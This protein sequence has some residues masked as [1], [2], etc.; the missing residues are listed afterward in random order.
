MEVPGGG[1]LVERDEVLCALD[2]LI[3]AAARGAGRVLVVE[4]PPGVGK[5]T[6]LRA[7]AE[8]ASAAGMR[9]LSAS[10][11]E[12]E[13]ELAY[14]VVR[15]LFVGVG[16]GADPDVDLWDGAAGLARRVVDPAAAAGDLRAEPSAVMHGLV[17][18]CASLARRAGLALLVDDVHWADDSSLRWL[19]YLARRAADLP[20]LVVLARRPLAATGGGD[21]LAGVIADPATATWPLESL[22][23]DGSAALVR[24][25]VGV[26][27]PAEI[28]RACHAATGGN[29]FYLSEMVAAGGDAL[30]SA[31]ASPVASLAPERVR[32]SVLARLDGLGPPAVEMARAIAVLGA[33]VEV[34]H[35]AALA[36]LDP[37]IADSVADALATAGILSVNR[38]LDFAHPIIRTAVYGVLPEGARSALH[39]RAAHVLYDDCSDPAAVAVQL[40][41]VEPYGDPWVSGRLQ[42][43]AGAARARGDPRAAAVYLLRALREPPDH[44]TRAEVLFVLGTVE[45]QLT[46]PAAGG[47][48]RE[49]LSLA[50]DPRRRAEIAAELLPMLVG[51]DGFAEARE[52]LAAVLPAAVDHAPDVAAEL[53]A[54]RVG[55]T[56]CHFAPVPPDTAPAYRLLE[57][58]DPLAVPARLL[59]G[60]LATEAMLRG[61]P[62]TDVWGL[63]D[64]SLSDSRGS[65]ARGAAD[66]TVLFMAAITATLCE[67]FE[68]SDRVCVD[69]L[70]E[71]QRRGSA[72]AAGAVWACR[73]QL[74][75]RLGRVLGAE[76]DARHAID[77]LAGLG[78]AAPPG[79]LVDA[80]LER[81]RP[82]EAVRTL[83]RTGFAGELA[84]STFSILLLARRIR[85]R[86]AAGS[87]D[88]A[89]AD[90]AT[91]ESWARDAGVERA[92]A[93]P[94]R[95]EGALACLAAGDLVRARKL[96]DAQLRLAEAFGAPG[97]R[98]IALR[99][100]GLAHGGDRGLAL[101]GDSVVVLAAT[102]MQLEHAKAL[103]ALGAA[104]RRVGERV[105]ARETLAAA[106]DLAGACGSVALAGQVRDELHVAGARPRRNR[107][108]GPDA[109]T[110]T[111]LRTAT[112]AQQGL[113]NTQIAQALFVTET[114]ERHLTNAYAKLGIRSRRELG[115]ALSEAEHADREAGH[116]SLM[117]R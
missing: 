3:A 98:G 49:A 79:Q 8:R 34:R 110:A 95:V 58:L 117:T 74:E 93:L 53:E 1:S 69:A 7:G 36:G 82:D 106:L 88:A 101:L 54:N 97:T 94:W 42:D 31:G 35:A 76:A 60:V 40:L 70:E 108:Y 103:A 29:P 14:G 43:A 18:L 59:R 4:G 30:L 72:F 20:V 89:L 84:P 80:L 91:A 100:A 68:L 12:L 92:C 23:E 27:V 6:V 51:P 77:A 65:I 24:R 109:L 22:S 83:E 16:R 75:F 15:Q 26:D 33:R 55:L 28:C 38:P 99:A 104:Q 46:A 21:L 2:A 116:A 63:L 114:V 111:E 9:A 37:R 105:Q 32:R 113:T 48:L 85:L 112:L 115:S 73:S 87:V 13:T 67:R 5:T 107:R 90:L 17:W 66:L 56:G 62:A 81:G 78:F 47:H 52:I 61:R 19:A 102:P 10:G 96:A 25:S 41:A 64:S 39:H 86:V 57:R 50:R 11:A 44:A 45:R 71:A